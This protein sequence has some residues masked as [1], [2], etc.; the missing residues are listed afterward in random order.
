VVECGEFCPECT[1]PCG[2]WDDKKTVGDVLEIEDKLD[3][4]LGSIQSKLELS[5]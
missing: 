3:L 4:G 1:H 2:L 5:G